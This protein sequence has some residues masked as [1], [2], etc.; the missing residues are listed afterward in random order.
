MDDE[1]H[2]QNNAKSIL[3]PNIPSAPLPLSLPLESYTGTYSHPAYRN[4]TITLPSSSS[5][6]PQLHIDRK[7]VTWKMVIDL[8]HVSG[9]HFIAR[10][11][12]LTAPDGNFK[13]AFPTE[14]RLGVDGTV[15]DFGARMEEE[16]GEEK[17]WFK[18]V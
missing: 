3:F 8:E 11:D 2:F 1:K 14:F 10:M 12:S 9:E 5:S 13:T 15:T 6:S 16:M 7:D 17:I 18:R 4:M